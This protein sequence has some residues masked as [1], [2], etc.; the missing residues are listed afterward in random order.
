[1]KY[2]FKKFKEKDM[3]AEDR[4]SIYERYQIGFPAK[5]CQDNK[6]RDFKYVVLFWDAGNRA[7][8][9]HFTNDEKEKSK[10]KI[11]HSKKGYSGMMSVRSFFKTH[12]IDPRKYR[13]RYKWEK[14]NIGRREE[15]F[16]IKLKGGRRGARVA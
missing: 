6:I 14:Y 9:L 15:V 11:N 1:M 2:R 3:G 5:F 10:F 8:G 7:I 4:I 12:K 16:V 13:D